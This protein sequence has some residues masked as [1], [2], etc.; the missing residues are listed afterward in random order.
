MASRKKLNKEKRCRS[1]HGTALKMKGTRLKRIL[2]FNPSQR[3]VNN[4][5]VF[6]FDMETGGLSSPKIN[7]MDMEL[8]KDMKDFLEFHGHVTEMSRKQLGQ[9]MKLTSEFEKSKKQNDG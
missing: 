4:K 7:M 3:R 5:F 6:Q 2:Y 8:S 1:Y 9:Y